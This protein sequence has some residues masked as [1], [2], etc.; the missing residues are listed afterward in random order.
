VSERKV[1]TDDSN[2]PFGQYGPKRGDC[3]KMRDVPARY[4]LWLWDD[5]LWQQPGPVHDYILENYSAL[6]SD[7]PDY[8]PSHKPE[9]QRR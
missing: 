5:G 9:K 3:R 2:M 8:I 4:L 7:T 1:L 6:E